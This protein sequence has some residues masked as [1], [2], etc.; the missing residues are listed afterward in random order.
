MPSEPHATTNGGIVDF[1]SQPKDQFTADLVAKLVDQLNVEIDFPFANE[2]QEARVI[3][4]AVVKVANVLPLSVVEFMAVASDG[5]S[6][7]ELKLAEDL[8]VNFLN[9]RVDVPWMPEGMEES[10]LRPLV[11]GVLSFAK[12]SFGLE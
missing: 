1:Q 5:L 6:D 9:A 3:R 2:E 10:V 11:A 4:I 12:V 7:S 8:I